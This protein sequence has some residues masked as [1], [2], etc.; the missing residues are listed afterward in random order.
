MLLVFHSP[1]TPVSIYTRTLAKFKIVIA[2][3]IVPFWLHFY[4]RLSYVQ[5]IYWY[6]VTHTKLRKCNV[7]LLHRN[8]AN[9]ILWQK[10]RYDQLFTSS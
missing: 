2:T 10:F 6:Q 1:R 8:V 3:Q 9:G 7:R 5:L 4:I